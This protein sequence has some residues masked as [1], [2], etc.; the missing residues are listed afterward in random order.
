MAMPASGCIGIITCPNSVACTSIAQAVDGNVTPP[1]SLAT[2]SA[3]AGKS[4]PHSM[5][6]FYS[7][8]ASFTVSMDVVYN[9]GGS[10]ECMEGTAC[11]RCWDTDAGVCSCFISSTNIASFD[12]NNIPSG[13]YYVDMSNVTSHLIGASLLTDYFW[14]D[15][16]GSGSGA[17]TDCFTAANSVSFDIFDGE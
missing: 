17:C 15:S 1:K 7:Y 5:T 12:W 2:L 6:E 3:T 16:Y 9:N 11:L 4:A 8:S 10:G 14:L 13:N